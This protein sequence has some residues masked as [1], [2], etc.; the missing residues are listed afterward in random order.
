MFELKLHLNG[1]LFV[2]EVLL[3]GDLLNE[4]SRTQQA[5]MQTEILFHF[6]GV[7][8]SSGI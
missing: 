3:N 2:N 5:F 8:K 6:L 4:I 1:A 7:C